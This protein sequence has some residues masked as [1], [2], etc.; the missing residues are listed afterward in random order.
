[1]VEVQPLTQLTGQEWTLFTSYQHLYKELALIIWVDK[2]QYQK[3]IPR[4]YAH[5]DEFC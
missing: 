3:F 4:W 5:V 1:M 2:E